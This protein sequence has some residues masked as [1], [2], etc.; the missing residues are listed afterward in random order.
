MARRPR[1]PEP[2]ETL[3]RDEAARCLAMTRSTCQPT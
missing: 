3:I 2:V 1:K